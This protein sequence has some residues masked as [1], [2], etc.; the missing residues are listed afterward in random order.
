MCFICSTLWLVLIMSVCEEGSVSD[1]EKLMED[2]SSVA[3]M[4]RK[5][6]TGMRDCRMS[7]KFYTVGIGFFRTV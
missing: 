3:N 4:H 6:S 7:V 5:S 1:L 2:I